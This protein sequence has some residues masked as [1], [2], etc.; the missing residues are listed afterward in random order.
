LEKLVVIGFMA[1]GKSTL[2]RH[3]AERLDWPLADADHVLQERL[4][5]PI[6]EF[7]DREGE[8]A[9]RT[10][11]RDVVLELLG[12]EGP[13]VVALGGGAVETDAIRTALAGQ[14][15]IHVDV[16]VDTAWA[17][18]EQS[19]T[20]RPLARDRGMFESLY[21]RRRPLYRSLARAVVNGGKDADGAC[22]AALALGRPGVPDTVRMLWARAGKGHPVYVGP[23]AAGAAGAL[24]PGGRCF[25]IA[26]ERALALHGESMLAA[27]SQATDVVE[28][29]AIPPG[30]QHKSL[31]EA[32]RVL[33]LLAR[34]GMQRA[35]TVLALGGGVVGDVA[36]FCAATYQRGVAVVHVPTTVV[37]QVDSAYGGKTGVDLP[38]AK[39]YVGAFH[40]PAAVLTDPTLLA[41]LPVEEIRAGY[42]EVV[43]TALIA[44][45]EL[46]DHVLALGPLEDAVAGGAPALATVIEQCVQTKLAVVA[47]DER[48]T[49]VRASLNLGHTLAH[50]LESATGYGEFRHGEAV[51]LG[52]LAALRISERELGLDPAVR[53]RVG[54]LIAGNGLPATFEGPPTDELLA[55]MDRDKKRSGA[56]RNLVLLRAPGDVAIGAEVPDQVLVESIEEL[57]G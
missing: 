31:A 10:R 14:V 20:K 30:E 15:V 4:G 28:T 51:A 52:L 12:S 18:A 36:G 43:K 48:D 57:R 1:A 19:S 24:W 39:N 53:A 41:T 55:H 45:G 32:E 56:R 50:A 29:I 38:E 8:D 5:E 21:E 40:Q 16:D 35:D 33:R 17:R 34:A 7:F 44:G 46:W 47:E 6:P 23:G 9:F 54:G 13:A 3:A 26:D 27:L 37:A 42:A 11:E 25:L 2:A 49:G 22:E